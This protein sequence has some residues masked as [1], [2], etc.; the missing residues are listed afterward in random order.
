VLIQRSVAHECGF[1]K[2]PTSPAIYKAVFHPE[3]K[4]IN[5]LETLDCFDN[6]VPNLLSEITIEMSN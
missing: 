6:C 4:K 5:G 2:M 3:R 1:P